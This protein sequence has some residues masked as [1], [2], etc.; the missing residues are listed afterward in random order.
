MTRGNSGNNNPNPNSN[1]I[2]HSIGKPQIESVKNR[3][4]QQ[5]QQRSNMDPEYYFRPRVAALASAQMEYAGYLKF[6]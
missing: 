1:F 3:T 6:Q 2:H 5:P 4:Q